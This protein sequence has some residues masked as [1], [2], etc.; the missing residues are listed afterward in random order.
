MKQSTKAMLLSALVFPGAG[1]LYL[2]R[3]LAGLLLS[4]AATVA[5]Y[6][7]VALALDT[8]LDI[9]GKIETGTVVADPLVIQEMVSIQLQTHQQTTRMATIA[10]S[11]C[12]LIGIIGS[13]WIARKEDLN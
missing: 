2:K 9:V 6:F 4:G 1:H 3:W 12:W 8:A 7:I 11:A 10:L 5:L 13:Y